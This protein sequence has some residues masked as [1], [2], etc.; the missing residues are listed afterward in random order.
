M[1]MKNGKQKRILV[2]EDDAPMARALRL[3]LAG[4]GYD[5]TVAFDGEEAM[6]K[7]ESGHDLILLD[8][9]LPK[10]DGFAVLQELRA[11]GDKAPIV[12][13]TNLGQD[14]DRKRVFDLGANGYYVKADTALS[15]IME[16]V[17]RLV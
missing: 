12:V 2:I 15:T 9:I 1:K 7:A 17:D 4:A 13:L 10:K 8:L 11:K 14:E 5:V 6:E 3:K 16:I